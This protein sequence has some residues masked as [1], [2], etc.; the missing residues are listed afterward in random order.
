MKRWDAV[1]MGILGAVLAVGTGAVAE[2]QERRP[3][4]FV[5]DSESWS[6]G[7]SFGFD[8]ETGF[9][10]TKGGAK[11]QTAEIV[12]TVHERCS[13]AI[14]TMKEERADYILVLQ[15]EGEKIFLRKDNKYVLFNADGDALAA[16]RR[17]AWATP[18]RTRARSY[19]RTG[20]TSCRPSATR[21]TV[22]ARRAEPPP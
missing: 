15:H 13:E 7:G 10:D 20:G 3:R 8:G 19:A 21:K 11:P 6:F 1:R 16:A 5:P 22:D 18:S 14:V 17:E 2:A 12:K 9:G 4:V